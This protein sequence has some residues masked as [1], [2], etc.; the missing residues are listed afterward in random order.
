MVAKTQDQLRPEF[1]VRWDDVRVFLALARERSLG[2][3]GRRLGLDTSTVSRRLRAFEDT[4]GVKL[5]ERTRAGLL[6]TRA[7]KQLVPEAEAIEAA[8]A[9]LQRAAS[10]PEAVAAE[11]T[12]RV[13]VP[14]GM[15]DA[16]VAPALARLRARH[17]R[18]SIE[19]DTSV[20][21]V[22]L[23]RHEA[24]VALRW[25]EPRGAELIVTKLMRS[26]WIAAAAPQLAREL[27]KLEAWQDAPWIA[28]DY[29]LASMPAAA[30][31]ARYARG[32][33]IALR[34]SHM[35]AQLKAA[36]A[37]LG[38]VLVPEA[39]L[40]VTALARVRVP[41]PLAASAAKLPADDLWLVG[42]RTQRE[43]PRVAAVWTFLAEELRR[44]G[45]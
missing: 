18:I 15:A 35:G 2:Q 39:Y 31:L 5:F 33:P 1:G 27:G 9:R 32:A 26:Q 22:D 20:R 43:L 19:L 13:S 25:L 45:R 11:G 10:A 28:W 7:G 21:A 14:P 42:H 36:E 6:A 3:A 24:D 37:G 29:D 30:W 41:P 23:T 4:L 44:L 17:P 38:F 12:V 8:H 40:K 16:F 34:T